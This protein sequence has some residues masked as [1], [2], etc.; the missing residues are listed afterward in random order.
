MRKVWDP[1]EVVACYFDSKVVIT[2]KSTC[3]VG[4]H[5]FLSRYNQWG[6]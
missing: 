1:S 5:V 2:S 4:G 6:E 3:D